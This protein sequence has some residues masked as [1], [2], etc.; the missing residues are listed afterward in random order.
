MLFTDFH[1]PEA[2][3]EAVCEHAA[4]PELLIHHAGTRFGHRAHY[5]LSAADHG[6]ASCEY[7]GPDQIQTLIK[8]YIISLN[9]VLF[10]VQ[11]ISY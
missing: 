9:H 11:I 6:T 8:K 3:D 2:E 5:F 10:F 1:T 4:M 7:V